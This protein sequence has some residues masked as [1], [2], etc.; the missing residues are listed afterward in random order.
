MKRKEKNRKKKKKEKWKAKGDLSNQVHNNKRM[1]EIV[2]MIRVVKK[3][4]KM[5]NINLTTTKGTR[6]RESSGWIIIMK[7][8]L[9]E[10]HTITPHCYYENKTK[11]TTTK[12]KFVSHGFSSGPRAA[13]QRRR[14]LADQIS[15]WASRILHLL[16][17]PS[18][19]ILLFVF[20]FPL[21]RP[22]SSFPSFFLPFFT[23]LLLVFTF[24]LLRPSSSFP[25][26]FLT[27]LLFVFTFL[28]PRPSS[29]F[30]FFFLTILVLFFTF[31]LL[32]PSSSFLPSSSLSSLSSSSS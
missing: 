21:L 10:H 30:P 18:L 6:E 16:P 25:S 28:L 27:I 29:S 12:K 26:F 15:H 1:I 2:L 4:V 13:K 14:G 3:I 5:I 22:S 7:E 31:L 23:I 17:L 8:Y 20:T 24:R 32:R 19:T 11:Q 9:S